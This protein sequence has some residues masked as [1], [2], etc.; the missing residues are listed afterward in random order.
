MAQEEIY[1]PINFMR[2]GGEEFDE[3]MA[4]TADEAV[5]AIKDLHGEGVDDWANYRCE[6]LNTTEGR[7][8]SKTKAGTEDL[9]SREIEAGYAR[10]IQV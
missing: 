3:G 10:P 6:G 5:Q 2:Q 8:W 7:Y 4:R 1:Y 9:Y